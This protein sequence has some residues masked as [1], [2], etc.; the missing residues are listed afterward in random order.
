MQHTARE[1]TTCDAAR[2]FADALSE[3][4]QR[5]QLPIVISVIGSVVKYVDNGDSV[6]RVGGPF[7]GRYRRASVIHDVYC[8]DC[9]QPSPQVHAMFH[10][11]MRADGVGVFKSWLMWFAVRVFG[12]RF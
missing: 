9:T 6:T 10:D 4:A 3:F 1:F 11:A 12:P 2:H 7:S 5:K 8:E